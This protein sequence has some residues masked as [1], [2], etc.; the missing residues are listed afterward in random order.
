[1]G[2][3]ARMV[4]L[5]LTGAA[6]ARG[7]FALV[8]SRWLNCRGVVL[9]HCISYLLRH[10]S[11]AGYVLTKTRSRAQ[12]FQG[13]GMDVVRG[14]CVIVTLGYFA[15][16]GCHSVTHPVVG[17]AW[18]W[19]LGRLRFHN[20]HR[21][22]PIDPGTLCVRFVR[23]WSLLLAIPFFLISG[24]IWTLVAKKCA[25]FGFINCGLWALRGV[26]LRMLFI[27]KWAQILDR[28]DETLFLILSTY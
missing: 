24:L 25:S 20:W 3:F 5:W 16:N 9:P 26:Y 12:T 7:G 15:P 28:L 17:P 11:C 10:V 1:M 13:I 23:R 14:W 27:R 2:V 6:L 19:V 18:G 8:V 22:D 21:I 4:F